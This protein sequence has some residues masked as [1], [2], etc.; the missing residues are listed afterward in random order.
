MPQAI[1]MSMRLWAMTIARASVFALSIAGM[2]EQSRTRRPWTPNTE[3]PGP[4]RSP[5]PVFNGR[6]GLELPDILRRLQR[7]AVR[8]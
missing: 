6:A 3:A 8:V 5:H 2:I 1:I 4:R 7:A